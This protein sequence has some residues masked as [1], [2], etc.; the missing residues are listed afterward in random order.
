MKLETEN[1][2]LQQY[3]WGDFVVPGKFFTLYH[4]KGEDID[5]VFSEFVCPTGRTPQVDFEI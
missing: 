1:L 3:E 5:S 2:S 4:H